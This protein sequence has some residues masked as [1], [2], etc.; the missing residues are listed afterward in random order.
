M[1]LNLLSDDGAECRRVQRGATRSTLFGLLLA[2]IGAGALIGV[3]AG[4]AGATGTPL[5]REALPYMV[6]PVLGGLSFLVIGI[7]LVL[8]RSGFD[9]DRRRGTFM[10]WTSHF[11]F[12]RRREYALDRFD[13]L[14]LTRYW[15][16]NRVGRNANRY[17]YRLVVRAASADQRDVELGHT[18]RAENAKDV[19]E[20]LGDFLGMAVEEVKGH[21]E[22]IVADC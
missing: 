20:R 1:R 5:P 7:M 10:S 9:F 12:Q 16:F 2:V 17:R 4:L 6:L 3:V 8:E 18:L 14:L 22:G 13:A 11:L 15:L 21:A 19:A